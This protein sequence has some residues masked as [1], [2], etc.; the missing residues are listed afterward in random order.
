MLYAYMK[1]ATPSFCVIE[2][3]INKC[4]LIN[5][6]TCLQIQA[7]ILHIHF[8]DCWENHGADRLY[9]YM[10]PDMYSNTLQKAYNTLKSSNIHSHN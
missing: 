3:T 7:I 9:K 2:C 8:N 6:S 1:L 5:V 4:L 10:C